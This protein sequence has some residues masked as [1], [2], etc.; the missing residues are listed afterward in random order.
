MATV[1]VPSIGVSAERWS[2][3]ASAASPDYQRGVETTQRD[4]AQNASAAEAAYKQGVTAAAN[5][6]RF[7]KGVA[8]AG[9][10]KWNRNAAGKGGDRYGPGAQAAT[11]DFST[12]IGPV[13]DVIK[14]TDLPA[15]GPRGQDSN[16]D[17]SKKIGQALRQFKTSR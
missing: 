2:R 9:D 13:L 4:W 11:G 17:R 3:R 7:G 6:G 8:R 5:A 14:S 10:A 12:A 15:K 1:V 16:Y